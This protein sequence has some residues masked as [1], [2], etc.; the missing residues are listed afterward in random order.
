FGGSARR[1]RRPPRMG[2]R[3]ANAATHALR[4]CESVVSEAFLLLPK[5]QSAALDRLLRGQHLVVSLSL[6]EEGD[7]V[8]AVRAKYN[9]MPMSLADAC[10]V[11]RSEM[12]ARSRDRDDVRAQG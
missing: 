9:D 12:S 5:A 8:L 2:A 4:T 6:S 3:N 10:L 11:R 7:A 1:A